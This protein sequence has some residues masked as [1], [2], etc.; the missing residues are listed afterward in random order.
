[1]VSQDSGQQPTGGSPGCERA[2]AC[3]GCG[4]GDRKQDF[5]YTPEGVRGHGELPNSIPQAGSLVQLLHSWW[6]AQG[7]CLPPAVPC[8][9]ALGTRVRDRGQR[10]HCRGGLYSCGLAVRRWGWTAGVVP[11]ECYRS[12]Q[13]SPPRAS[14]PNCKQDSSPR[15]RGPTPCQL[16]TP[17]NVQHQEQ[18]LGRAQAWGRSTRPVQE[19][20]ELSQASPTQLGARAWQQT[21]V[22]GAGRGQGAGREE[23]G[24]E[25]HPVPEG[26]LG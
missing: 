9:P 15:T 17:G 24:S 23:N 16:R 4:G 2:R 5:P 19:P 1:M 10:C 18:P 22:H 3:T 21:R 8:H 7:G 20:P 14:G 11:R 25:R 26:M 6:D 13:A 12:H